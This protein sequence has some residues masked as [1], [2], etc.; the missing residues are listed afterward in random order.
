MKTPLEEGL[1]ILEMYL[2]VMNPGHLHFDDDIRLSFARGG[3]FLGY[4]PDPASAPS[5]GV[6]V[7]TRG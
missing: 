3:D 2:E 4:D 5:V 6:A 1:V 7:K